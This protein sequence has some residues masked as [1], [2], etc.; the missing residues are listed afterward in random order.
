MRPGWVKKLVWLAWSL[1]GGLP[2][3][4]AG[5]G[6][7]NV[8]VVVNGDSWAS[9]TIANEFVHGR[10]IPPA[11]VIVLTGVPDHEQVNVEVLRDRVLRPV[12]Q[13][14]SDR[15]LAGQ[16]D[17]VVYSC[18]LPYAVDVHRDLES[19]PQKPP[20]VFTPTASINGLTFLYQQVLARDANYLQLNS[21]RYVRAPL[22]PAGPK[23]L[24]M[25]ELAQYRHALMLIGEKKWVQAAQV[26]RSLGENHPQQP[27]LH[28]NLACCLAR[29]GKL[30]EALAALRA[31]AAAG[32]A[33]RAHAE[34]D[35]DLEPLRGRN[36]FQ[37]VLA[38]MTVRQIETQPTLGFRA[39]YLWD[40][41]GQRTDGEGRRYLLST[42]LAV[43]SG[44]GTSVAEAVA[45]LRRSMR[46]DG[47]RPAGT[48]YF[49][50]NGDVRSRTRDALFP[51]AVA[52]LAEL[53]VR[54]EILEGVL[55]VGRSDVAGAMI[56]AAGFDWARS[57]STILPGAICEHLTSFGGVLR[58]GAGQTPLSEFI[59]HGAAGASGTV[60]EP[61]AIQAKF[62]LPFLHVHYARGCSL[63]EAFYQSVAGPYQLLIVGDPLCSPW[64]R[65]PEVRVAG[66]EPRQVARGVLTLQPAAGEDPTDIAR[67]ELFLDGRRRA[68]C[69]PGESLRLDTAELADGFHEARVV[70][71]RNDAVETQGHTIV[72]FRVDNR[73]RQVRLRLLGE[74]R[75][76][77]DA[78]V[79]IAADAP[80][81]RSIWLFHHSRKLAV[82]EGPS[83]ASSLDAAQLG[84]GPVTLSA[85]AE[86][87]GQTVAAEPLALELLPPDFL[88][89]VEVPPG[90]EFEDGLVLTPA[91]GRGRVIQHTRDPNWLSA[92]GLAPGTEFTLAAYFQVERD[93][94]YQVQLHGNCSPRVWVDEKP[95]GA[96]ASDGWT[97]RPAA[98]SRGRHVLR[99]TGTAGTAPRLQIRFG[100]SGTRSLDGREFRHI[101]LGPA[102]AVQ[103]AG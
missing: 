36:E 43:T 1:A 33:N 22:R 56:G 7:E 15:N 5:G 73:G 79:R 2:P 66:L 77:A 53:G 91:Q 86:F 20:P 72:P 18:D 34:Q 6:P 37:E 32:W 102:V 35:D 41:R 58:E 12:L 46:A 10:R 78:P 90:T 45:A 100:G 81:A 59:R 29:Q 76:R 14:I 17:Y 84:F 21:N 82:I 101:D 31:A 74:N 103:P 83:G 39:D 93:D 30:D 87:D 4:W 44:R 19:L 61:Y 98:L 51:S 24:S 69:R 85:E 8:A 96:P 27:E 16:I 94:V 40:D 11:N 9:L 64:A 70:A 52:R 48:I 28:Y 75:I 55:P 57:Q 49:L 42:M 38:E 54:A 25:E 97:F 62:P 67:F 68:V 47:S 50:K 63:A 26:L 95:L 65:I 23:P 89:P 80:G 13:A 99:L 71:V 60:T 88:P 92:A 3:A